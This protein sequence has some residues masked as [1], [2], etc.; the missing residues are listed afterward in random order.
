[1]IVG[2]AV[3]EHSTHL[4]SYITSLPNRLGSLWRLGPQKVAQ[5][6]FEKVD[7]CVEPK[8]EGYVVVIM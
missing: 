5:V 2:F 6:A 7:D 8:K 3:L 4:Q 1:M